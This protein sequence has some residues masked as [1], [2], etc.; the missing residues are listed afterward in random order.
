MSPIPGVPFTDFLEMLEISLEEISP[1]IV[2][3]RLVVTIQTGT[4]DE[5][6]QFITPTHFH[7]WV[8]HLQTPPSLRNRV[9]ARVKT[10]MN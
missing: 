8:N 2:S 10:K 6:N 3:G 9:M 1:E 5:G 4:W 7:A